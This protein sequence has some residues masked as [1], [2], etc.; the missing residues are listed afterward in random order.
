MVHEGL[1]VPW[2]RKEAPACGDSHI[3][4]YYRIISP[5]VNIKSVYIR[6]IVK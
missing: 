4:G 3:C 1:R 2:I 5:T 6:L